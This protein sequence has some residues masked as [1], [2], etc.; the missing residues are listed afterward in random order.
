MF[1]SNQKMENENRKNIG[2]IPVMDMKHFV[3]LLLAD[4]ASKSPIIY[5][6]ERDKKTACLNANY[7]EIIEKIMYSDNGWGNK[8]AQLIDITSYYEYQLEW[9]QKLAKTIKKVCIELN[10]DYYFNI[11]N[12]NIEIYFTENEIDEIKSMYDEKALEIMGHFSNLISSATFTREFNLEMK[13]MDRDT[14][15]YTS[16]LENLKLKTKYSN[17]I[18]LA[19][20]LYAK[21][22]TEEKYKTKSI[23]KTLKTIFK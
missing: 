12:N 15:R 8:F 2:I 6:D 7:K 19:K 5:F 22:K 16:Y 9:E 11:E 21:E 23:K 3:L 1:Y 14:A 18:P 4:L 10:K 20:P 17:A 13:N